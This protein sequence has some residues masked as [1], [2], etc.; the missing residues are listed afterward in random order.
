MRNLRALAAAELR[1]MGM[2]DV[3]F[4]SARIDGV[5]EALSVHYV[6]PSDPSGA[7]QWRTIPVACD[8]LARL[9][10][11]VTDLGPSLRD[12]QSL[13]ARAVQMRETGQ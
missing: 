5:G 1:D 11:C 3:E 9:K 13:A 4:R 12:L 2:R 8:W 7:S 6:D 10:A